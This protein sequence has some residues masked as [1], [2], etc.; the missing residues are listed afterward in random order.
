MKKQL[1]SSWLVIVLILA[2][3]T[4]LVGV[5]LLLHWWKGIPFG[6]M[7][8]DPL[9][10]VGGAFYTGFLSQVGLFFWSAAAA[11]CLFCATAL[12]R[13]PDKLALKRF[14]VVSGLLT[15]VLALDDVFLLHEAFFPS[16]GVPEK[17]V[18]SCYAGFVLCYLIAFHSIILQTEFVLLF[19][20]LA[21]FGVSIILDLS[22]FSWLDPFLLEDGA[23][24]VGIVSWFSYFF[25][26]GQVAVK[27]E[28]EE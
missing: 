8:R 6:T 20:A 19:M 27:R 16:I 2:V 24:L 17:L 10:V 3:S 15:L 12:S 1:R 14:L 18:F 23:K 21:F 9:A 4:A 25:R 13:R 11:V 5:V 28:A 26:V 22:N 7:T